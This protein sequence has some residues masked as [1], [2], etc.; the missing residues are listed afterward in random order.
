LVFYADPFFV[1]FNS[2]FC[3]SE[4]STLLPCCAASRLSKKTYGTG[5]ACLMTA[6][7]TTNTTTRRMGR[8]HARERTMGGNPT[9]MVAAL[10][11]G[12]PLVAWGIGHRL[13]APTLPPP[14]PMTTTTTIAAAVGG[15]CAPLPSGLSCP[16]GRRLLLLMSPTAVD[17][18]GMGAFGV[19]SYAW[20]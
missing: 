11:A 5:S 12:P 7:T 6:A 4:S 16:A 3:S 18:G 8:G 2:S 10:S 13:S 9:T 19:W 17:G 20:W 14:S 15:C 1:S